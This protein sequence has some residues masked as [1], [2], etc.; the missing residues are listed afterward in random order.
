MH[1]LFGFQAQYQCQYFFFISCQCNF[2]NKKYFF[3]YIQCFFN[4][5]TMIIYIYIYII[6]I[7]YYT[8]NVCSIS[9]LMMQCITSITSC[10]QQCIYSYLHY[11]REIDI[12]LSNFFCLTTYT[13]YCLFSL[14]FCIRVIF[15]LN[16]IITLLEND[17]PITFVLSL[18]TMFLMG[19][20]LL[21]ICIFFPSFNYS[22]SYSIYICQ[23]N[24]FKVTLLF[25]YV[26]TTLKLLLKV[27]M[28]IYLLYIS[29]YILTSSIYIC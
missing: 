15:L 25:T 5:Y 13:S 3:N 9:I 23:V 11:Y 12:H 8:N 4:I 21:Q 16:L 18:C 2:L 19:G 24:I 20:W 27:Q 26:I 14:V 29:M 17:T 28:Y 7:Y 22:P 10:N 6:S 1:Q